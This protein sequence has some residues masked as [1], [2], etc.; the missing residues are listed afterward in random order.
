MIY[1]NA[2]DRTFDTQLNSHYC[3]K[4]FVNVLTSPYPVK[5]VRHISDSISPECVRLNICS[6]RHV[7]IE[8]CV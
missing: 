6:S 4:N 1:C 5:I 3:Q 2:T 8:R 7:D